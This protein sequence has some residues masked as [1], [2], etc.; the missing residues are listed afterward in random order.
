MENSAE[1]GSTP[2]TWSE[3]PASC[4]AETCTNGLCIDG[5]D[6]QQSCS[7]CLCDEQGIELQ[8]CMAR[9]GVCMPSQSNA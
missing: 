3:K 6:L 5:M 2:N 1:V 4:D 8:H 7:W 9:S